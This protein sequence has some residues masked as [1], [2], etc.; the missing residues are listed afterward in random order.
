MVSSRR[1]SFACGAPP[2]LE[3]LGDVQREYL[4]LLSHD[5]G[6]RLADDPE[7]VHQMRVATRARPRISRST[8]TR[9]A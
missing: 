7:D 8:A 5:P 9:E 3:A 1:R 4:R 2:A 6:V